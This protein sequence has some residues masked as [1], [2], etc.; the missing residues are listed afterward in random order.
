MNKKIL[1]V[2]INCDTGLAVSEGRVNTTAARYIEYLLNY[3][4]CPQPIGQQELM[5]A[6]RLAVKDGTI[7][8]QKYEVRFENVNQSIKEYVV[9]DKNGRLSSWPD[10]L[11]GNLFEH[12]L[13]KII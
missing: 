11:P 8:S 13:V 9:V 10:W 4:T 2:L 6:I 3:E 5:L 1:S 7:D 12:M